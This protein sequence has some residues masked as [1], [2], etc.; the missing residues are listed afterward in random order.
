RADAERGGKL[1]NERCSR[2]AATPP[3]ADGAGNP[4]NESEAGQERNAPLF[5]RVQLPV[6]SLLFAF[7]EII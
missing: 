4:K 5:P 6:F 2:S 1:G 3:N 7:G